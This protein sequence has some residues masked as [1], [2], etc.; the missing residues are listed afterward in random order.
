MTRYL[1]DRTEEMDKIKIR[2]WEAS[3]DPE[4]TIFYLLWA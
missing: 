1:M 3:S 4:E 2:E